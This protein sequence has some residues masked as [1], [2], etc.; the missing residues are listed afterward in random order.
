MINDELTVLPRARDLCRS[1]TSK[2]WVE[3]DWDG[4]HDRRG[5]SAFGFSNQPS[6]KYPQILYRLIGEAL[7]S[8][9]AACATHKRCPTHFGCARAVEKH[10]RRFYSSFASR[11]PSLAP[12]GA[13]IQEDTLCATQPRANTYSH[14]WLPSAGLLSHRRDDCRSSPLGAKAEIIFAPNPADVSCSPMRAPDRSSLC[15]I[16]VWANSSLLLG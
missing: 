5:I 6:C 7:P 4:V 10:K 9:P 3:K 2:A 1:L 15:S 11:N 13:I 16:A 14:C 8:L 12:A